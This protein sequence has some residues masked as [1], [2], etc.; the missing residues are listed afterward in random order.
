MSALD[1]IFKILKGDLGKYSY[2]IPSVWLNENSCK[3]IKVDPC[4]Y[5]GEIIDEILKKRKSCIS[6]NKS[7]SCIKGIQHDF[8]GDWTR[9]SVIYNIFVRL[10][11]AYDHNRDGIVGGLS[12]DSTL[13]SQGIR[14]TGTFLKAIALLPYIKSLGV[15]TIH[16]LPVNSIGI[17]GNKGDLGSPYA[18]KNPY[19]IDKNLAD[20]L[21]YLPAEDQFKAFIEAAHI[22]DMRV[23]LEFVFRTASKD[24]DWIKTHPEWFYWIDKSMAGN[25]HSPEFSNEELEEILKVPENNGKYIPPHD[26]YKNQFKIPPTPEEIKFINNKFIAK[27]E[28][29]ELIIPGAFAD[30]P[31]NDVQPPWSDVTYLRMY[32]YP[33]KREENYNYIAYNTIRYYDPELAKL[34]NTNKDLWSMI[35]NI[36]P[37][38]QEEF[39]IDGV[40]I[41]MGHALPSELK[42][43][44]ISTARNIDPDFA[45]WDENFQISQSSRDDGYNA[46]IGHTWATES[47][48]NGLDKTLNESSQD[49][50]L[51]YFGTSETHNTPRAV[52]KEGGIL[53][54]K[55]SFVL[56]CFMPNSIPFIHSGF[57]LGEKLPVNTG[58]CFTR[59]EL[60]FFRNKKLPLFYK[61]SFNWL[62]RDNMVEF[63]QKITEIRKNYSDLI[64]N[65]NNIRILNTGNTKII[66]FQRFNEQTSL[67]V[68][69]NTNIDS[70]E[71]SEIEINSKITELKDKISGKTFNVKDNNLHI[72]LKNGEIMIIAK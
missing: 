1:E 40:M 46:V 47:E 20:P 18:I 21:V 56:N 9:N 42:Q 69:M 30:W 4:R 49:M 38:Y 68:I 51:P 43:Q 7:F 64:T 11:T 70:T 72:K 54:S 31:P 6:Y 23:V 48:E 5:F 3:N 26:K 35:N 34:E 12:T 44:M 41:D 65:S 39:G 10:T 25:Y 58:L 57:E 33:F 36:I 55:L 52:S 50:P 22:L 60:K 19:E 67:T 71:T 17:D 59:E 53:F 2:Y 14:E 29:G 16:L 8:P 27:T 63:I 62:R 15:N 13:N 32:N 45:F 66:A 28:D 61:S 37:Y 24:A